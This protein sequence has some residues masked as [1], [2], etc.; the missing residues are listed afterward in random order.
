MDSDFFL[1][2]PVKKTTKNNI[3]IIYIVSPLMKNQCILKFSLLL[4]NCENSFTTRYYS[5]CVRKT[6]YSPV[7]FRYQSLFDH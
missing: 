4:Y 5:F 2:V 3:K 1:C 6:A 7:F